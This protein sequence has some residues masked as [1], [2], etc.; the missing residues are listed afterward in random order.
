MHAKAL[1][2]GR[3]KVFI[4]SANLDPRSLRLNTEIGLLVYSETLNAEVRSMVERDFSQENAWHLQ[5]DEEGNVTW[6]PFL[7]YW[8]IKAQF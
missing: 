5:F 1:V 6:V 7:R 3:D 8:T 2:I 4:G